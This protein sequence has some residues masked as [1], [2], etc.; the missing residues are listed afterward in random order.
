MLL[1]QTLEQIT[2]CMKRSGLDVL[3]LGPS[4]DLEYL[5]G[6]HPLHDERFM[7]LFILSDQRYFYISPELYYAETR[8]ILGEE[9][10]IL[11]WGDSEGFLKAIRQADETY[12]LSRKKIGINDGIL[13]V[14]MLDIASAIDPETSF[15]KGSHIIEG[16]RLIKNKEERALLREASHIADR[17]AGEIPRHIKPGMSEKNVKEVLERLLIEY[18]GEELAFQTIVASGPN[19]ANPH[20]ADSN[21]IIE[22]QDLLVLDFGCR[23][24][25]Y[26][27]DISRTVFVGEPTPLQQEIYAIVSKANASGKAAVRAGV[28]AHSVDRA[29]RSVIEAAGYGSCFVNRTGHGVGI[30]VHEAPYIKEG[31]EQLLQNGMVFSIEPGIY[32]PGQFGMRIEDLVLIEHGE[33][34]VLNSANRKLTI[35]G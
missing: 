15:Y 34:V 20:Y 7:A 21:R 6:L 18:G 25:G 11:K 32:I 35:A 1:N 29:A 3:V 12:T 10:S 23:Y 28:S 8:A 31:N 5:T 16:L 14:S 9:T 13:A 27:S 30:A 19:S 4:G 33:A 17:V 24:K 22:S 26:C 2:D